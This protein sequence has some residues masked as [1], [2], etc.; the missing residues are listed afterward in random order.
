VSRSA[1]FVHLSDHDVDRGDATARAAAAASA[2]LTGPLS[3]ADSAMLRRWADEDS[4]P[5]VRAAA[6][7]ALVRAGRGTTA[8]EVW[9]ARRSD[10]ASV[11][12]RR[13]AELAPIVHQVSL[14]AV[15]E[16]LED[17][18]WS[19]A[20]TAAWAVGEIA[21]SPTNRRRATL[22]LAAL[23]T[24]HDDPLVREA[25]VAAIGALGEVSGLAAVLA[26]TH[27]RPA[28]R[29]RAVL[30]LAPFD[31]AEV[32]AALTRSL[33]DAD[34]QVRQAAQDLLGVEV[35]ADRRG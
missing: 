15:V 33:E 27:D 7:A 16:L 32:D 17:A 1:R 9:S 2:A 3:R 25:A 13:A 21:W 30:A 35:D 31:G 14:R 10:P 4:D 26:A 20:E 6:L 22:R 5:R 23:A 8:R 19:V 24:S 11:V 34:W 28:I 12:R 18:D 29:R